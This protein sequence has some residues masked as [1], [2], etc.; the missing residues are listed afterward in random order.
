MVKSNKDTNDLKK[1][2][3][4]V[5]EADYSNNMSILCTLKVNR[6]TNNYIG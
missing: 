4:F 2:V 5:V 1:G 3:D 6:F